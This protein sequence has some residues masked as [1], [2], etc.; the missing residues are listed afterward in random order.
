MLCTNLDAFLFVQR[1][2]KKKENCCSKTDLDSVAYAEFDSSSKQGFLLI[3][4][5]LASLLVIHLSIISILFL[6]VP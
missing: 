6:L 4:L 3:Y 1:G 5:N 2:K